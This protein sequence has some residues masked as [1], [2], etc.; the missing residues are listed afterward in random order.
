MTSDRSSAN[1]HQE[2]LLQVGAGGLALAPDEMLAKLAAA[3][4]AS[5]MDHLLRRNLDRIHGICRRI[6]CH[7]EDAKD[8][9]QEALI[10]I[11]RSVDT[12]DGRSAFA[13]WMYRVATNAALMEVRRRSRRPALLLDV[14]EGV[15][16]ADP[17]TSI[18]HLLDERVDIDNALARLA[19]EFRAAVVLRDLCDLDYPSIA[20]ILDLPEGTVRSRIHRGRKALRALL[21]DKPNV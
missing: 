12:F 16:P 17:S 18:S 11:H 4:D 6:T 7:P 10:A 20:A 2:H 3:G 15:P 9:T 8:A 13:T 19:P 5:A 21:D 14:G 1:G